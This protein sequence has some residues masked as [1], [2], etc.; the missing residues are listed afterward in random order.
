MNTMTRQDDLEEQAVPDIPR[1]LIDDFEA[2]SRAL[3]KETPEN[4]EPEAMLERIRWFRDLKLSNKIHAI[5]GTFFG[6]GFAMAL[7]LGLGLTELWS[8]YQVSSQVQTAVLA[9]SDLR[10]TTGE[11]RYNTARFLFEREPAVLERQRES[12]TAAIAQIDQIDGIVSEHVP[13]LEARVDQARADL[14]EYNDTFSEVLSVMQR[15]GRSR[16]SEALAYEI[17]DRGDALFEQSRVFAVDLDQ[18]SMRLQQTG[19]DY[20]FTMIAIVFGLGAFA[21]IILLFGLAYLSRDFSRKISEVTDGMNKLAKGDRHF[22]IVGRDRKDEIGQMVSALELF[23]RANRRLEVW[24]RERAEHAEAEVELQ[25]ERENERKEADAHKARLLAE[26]ATQFE[27][28]VGDVVHK[29]AAASSELNTTAGK[30]ASAAEET[31]ER[32]TLVAQNMAEANSGAT[33][34]AAASDEFALSIG[35]I[36]QQAASSSELARL[37]TDATN[38]ADTTISALAD[39]AEEVGQIVELIQTIAQRTNLLA[40]NAS[41]EAARGGEA[42]RGFA[43][44]ASEVKELAMQTSRATEKVAEQIRA[45]QDTTGASVNALRAIARQVNELETTA[46]SIASAVDQQSVAGQDL[47]RSI[48]LAARGTEQVSGHLDE[49]RELS[50]STGAAASQVLSS[51]NE[52]EVQASTLGDQVTTFLRRVREG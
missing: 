51:A 33:S 20:F 47:A 48:D 25:Q 13:Q 36:S 34:A 7:V 31:S 44:V 2:E 46:V 8:R 49:V 30:M 11:L 12:Y 22:E 52:L 26:L 21:A 37:A 6:V 42:G 40:L 41:I 14:V 18:Y 15:E 29:V 17:S 35:E 24:A 19:S 4:L 27:R 23:K 39:S 43:V 9:S 3:A 5:F 10:G 16:N 28:T 50:L 38:E 32:T 1:H 45:M